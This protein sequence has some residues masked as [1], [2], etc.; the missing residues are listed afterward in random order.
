MQNLQHDCKFCIY[1]QNLHHDTRIRAYGTIMRK[2]RCKYS[3]EVA[4]MK[5]YI[6]LPDHL[7][8]QCTSFLRCEPTRVTI[9]E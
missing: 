8:V 4:E 3:R 9:T 5:K 1:C 6:E 2:K 7:H